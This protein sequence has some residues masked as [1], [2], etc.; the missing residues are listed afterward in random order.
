[1][2]MIPN[3]Q[4]EKFMAG[5]WARFN[6]KSLVWY[7]KAAFDEAG[8]AVPTTWEELEQLE[9][10]IIADGDTPWCIGIESGTATGW[11]VTDWMEDLMLRTTTPENYDRWVAGDLKFDSPEVRRAAE[12]MSERFLDEKMAE[13]G[14][15]KIVAT[16]FM[17]APKGMFTD[18]PT[19]WLHRQ[20][21]FITSFFPEGSTPGEDWSFFYLPGIDEEYGKP[22][23]V[24]GDIYAMFNDR[25]EVRAVMEFFTTGES[26]REWIASGGALSPHNDTLLEWYGNETERGI[27]GLVRDANTLRFDA[28]DLMPGEVGSGSFWKSMTSYISGTT[29]L[30]TALKEIDESWPQ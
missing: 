2:S 18:P 5:I 11:P 23:L 28:S 13:G 30:D 6:G 12:I 8:Y 4:G 29:D 9:Q 15:S 27:A 22:F 14:P 16:S 10:D 20:G 26:L 17:D 1:M 24:A 21:N 19:C 7:P 25:P 3:A